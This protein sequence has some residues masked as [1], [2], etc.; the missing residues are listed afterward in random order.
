MAEIESLKSAAVYMNDIL[1]D[2]LSPAITATLI[3]VAFCDLFWDE[4]WP[5]IRDACIRILPDNSTWMLGVLEVDAVHRALLDQVDFSLKDSTT[6]SLGSN[7]GASTGTGLLTSFMADA[8]SLA[9]QSTPARHDRCAATHHVSFQ[10]PAAAVKLQ[11]DNAPVPQPSDEVERWLSFV[12]GGVPPEYP[13]FP[14]VPPRSSSLSLFPT[15]TTPPPNFSRMSL[16]TTTSA[17]L[18][19]AAAAIAGRRN[20][21][22]DTSRVSFSNN[23]NNNNRH[24][25]LYTPTI[26]S[27]SSISA[28]GSPL[29]GYRAPTGNFYNSTPDRD[30]SYS[31][32]TSCS[33]DRSFSQDNSID[34][35]P[36]PAG[37]RLSTLSRKQIKKK[38]KKE[39]KERKKKD[40]NNSSRTASTPGSTRTPTV[41][42][43]AGFWQ[44]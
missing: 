5:T 10:E 7:L 42:D 9:F 32:S 31:Y 21:L 23:N 38:D 1:V 41:A 43:D 6:K 30:R 44:C 13:K 24:S 29:T 11:F 39:K 36:T 25:L 40:G 3:D 22:P 18:A 12:F 34:G 20:S 28:A 8:P 15:M 33:N 4:V 19:Q 35:S 26:A 17:H 2:W 16:L 37:R 27:S 14:T